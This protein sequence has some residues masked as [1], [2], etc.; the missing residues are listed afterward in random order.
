MHKSIKLK[1][2][3]QFQECNI[4]LKHLMCRKNYCHQFYFMLCN[5]KQLKKKQQFVVY[6]RE[7]DNYTVTS[8]KYL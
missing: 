5:I 7:D 6:A 2:T 4:E 3:L 1:I 8:C